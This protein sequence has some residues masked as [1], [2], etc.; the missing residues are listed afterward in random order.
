MLT[1]VY[2]QTHAL[3]LDATYNTTPPPIMSVDSYFSKLS[4]LV[5]NLVTHS[6][7]DVMSGI[8]PSRGGSPSPSFSINS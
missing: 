3:V 5:L 1:S 2:F 7:K 8:D 4:P 6:V